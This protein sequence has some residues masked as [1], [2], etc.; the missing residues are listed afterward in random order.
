[1][2]PRRVPLIPS[3]GGSPFLVLGQGPA[4]TTQTP[5]GGGDSPTSY[6]NT[7]I[8]HNPMGYWMLGEGLGATVAVDSSGR[9]HPGTYGT[10]FTLGQD[11]GVN[12]P[13][14]CVLGHS[15]VNDWMQVPDHAD[16][17][18][19]VACSVEVW[20]A[21]NATGGNQRIVQ[22]GASDQGIRIY[23][24]DT[25]IFAKF[26]IS[27]SDR[28]VQ[29]FMP[30]PF[31]LGGGV[32]GSFHHVI[33]TWASG[34]PV[35]LWYDGVNVVSSAAFS[36][37]LDSSTDALQWGS[38]AG[39]GGTTSDHFNG[40]LDEAAFYGTE[41]TSGQISSH[42]TGI[43]QDA[44]VQQSVSGVLVQA[45]VQDTTPAMRVS[46]VMTQGVVQDT[47]PELR[48]SNVVVQAVVEEFWHGFGIIGDANLDEVPVGY[49]GGAAAAATGRGKGRSKVTG[50]KYD[51]GTGPA[52]R[53]NVDYRN[54]SDY[55]G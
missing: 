3:G 15:T 34:N 33:L 13:D 16:F 5:P 18:P 49:S 6:T 54:N 42:Y 52:Y 14:D 9:G 44:D 1:M 24:N 48:V 50:T 27:G 35:R 38:K 8:G 23:M 20:F 10:G 17:K 41:L 51:P 37:T 46:S 26:R 7:V 40:W 36:G 29:Y 25:D 4:L 2:S 12:R 39:Q 32:D 19:T 47:T 11:F 22:K 53:K 45:P 21:R 28:T 43:T 55:R 30:D 31:G